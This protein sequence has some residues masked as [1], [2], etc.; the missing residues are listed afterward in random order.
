MIAESEVINPEITLPVRWE[1]ALGAF[2]KAN[3]LPNYL[4]AEYSKV[5]LHSR[6]CECDR[7]HSQI[8]NKD[9]EWYLRSI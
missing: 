9:F 3:I 1:T 8:G 2:E 5:F 4:G 7:F 6:R